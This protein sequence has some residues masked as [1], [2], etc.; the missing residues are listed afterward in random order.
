MFV[1][2]DVIH[3]RKAALVYSLFVKLSIWKKTEE[4]ICKIIHAQ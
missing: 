1:I 3:R 2:Y 4:L